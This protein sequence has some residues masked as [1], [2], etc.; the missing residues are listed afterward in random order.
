MAS[1]LS[2]LLTSF[3]SGTGGLRTVAHV[4][5]PKFMGDWYVIANIPYFAEKGCVD[6]VESY[7]LRAD[8]RIDNGFAYRKESFEAP[9]QRIKALAW[10]HDK[11][12]NAEWRVRFF[13]IL[14]VKYLVLDLDKDYRWAVIGHPSRDYG[15][16]LAR[17]KTLSEAEYRAILGRLSEQG[18]DPGRFEKVP[19]LP[20]K[21]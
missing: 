4:D 9:V 16:V 11:G 8:G 19:Q 1:F 12:S 20:A 18:Y 3:K 10:V 14:T 5:L 2:L 13:G 7:A 21:G 6:S 17:E 15:W